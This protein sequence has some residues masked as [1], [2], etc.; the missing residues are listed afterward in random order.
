MAVKRQ[1]PG[2]PD[3]GLYT[4]SQCGRLLELEKVV[5]AE[6]ERVD[7]C[8]TGYVNFRH[9]CMC[10]PGT[11]LSSRRWG[12]YPSFRALFGTM[13]EMPYKGPFAWN[14]EADRDPVV[15][16]WSWELAQVADVREFILFADDAARR[17]AA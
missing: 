11:V 17:R 14:V 7:G 6:V 9:H 13:P 10:L 2:Q 15:Q 1:D 5:S 4:C 3:W 8:A 16:R 12:S